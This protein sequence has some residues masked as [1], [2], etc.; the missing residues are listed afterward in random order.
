MTVTCGAGDDPW[1]RA[2]KGDCA[3]AGPATAI[4]QIIP[5]AHVLLPTI[6]PPAKMDFDQF[7]FDGKGRK[8]S[9]S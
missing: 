7:Y 3:N 6:Y 4:P 1:R 5:T 9:K 2:E 8:N